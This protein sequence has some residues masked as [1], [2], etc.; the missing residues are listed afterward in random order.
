MYHV[1]NIFNRFQ[2]L[3]E[4]LRQR[5]LIF[6]S[7]VSLMWPIFLRVYKNIRKISLPL[8]WCSRNNT[9]FKSFSPFEFITKTSF[10]LGLSKC[11]GLP[12]ITLFRFTFRLLILWERSF[13]LKLKALP[14]IYL[15]VIVTFVL[16]SKRGAW[17]FREGL[18]LFWLVLVVVVAF[19][20]SFLSIFHYVNFVTDI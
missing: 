2:F 3:N 7:L 5:Y 11:E 10:I 12:I 4:V 19:A 6:S 20:G 17:C 1:S 13:T 9:F 16:P 14:L 15:W 8:M 18:E